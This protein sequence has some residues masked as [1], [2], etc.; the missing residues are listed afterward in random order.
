[1]DGAVYRVLWAGRGDRVV[2]VASH[3]ST[4]QIESVTLLV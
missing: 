3:R 4:Q 2:V 1:V